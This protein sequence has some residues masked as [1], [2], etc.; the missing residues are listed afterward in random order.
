MV[1]QLLLKFSDV[2]AASSNDL[3]HTDLIKHHI[4]T[5]NAH[6][7]RQQTQSVPPAKR[8]DTQELLLNMLQHDII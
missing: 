5:S 3:G 7:I 1:L 4:D 8:E 6:P 2:F